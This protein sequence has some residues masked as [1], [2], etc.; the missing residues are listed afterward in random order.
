MM[1]AA[2]GGKDERVEENTAAGTYNKN[3]TPTITTHLVVR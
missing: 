2:L 3:S 1:T